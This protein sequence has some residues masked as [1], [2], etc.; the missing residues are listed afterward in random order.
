MTTLK[1]VIM[2]NDINAS[3]FIDDLIGEDAFSGQIIRARRESQGLTQKDVSDMT[4]IKTT[5]LS[6]VEN[7][8]R[9][10]G[11]QTAT[12]IAA[13]IGLHP[14]SILFPNGLSTTKEIEKI[15]KMRNKILKEKS[16]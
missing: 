13:A 2:K 1:D 3:D 14:S 16:A 7:D 5:F 10:I 11:V 6:A 4:G 15:I 8:K 9:N 12:K